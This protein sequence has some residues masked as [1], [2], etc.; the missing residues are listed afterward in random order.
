[1]PESVNAYPTYDGFIFLAI[2]NDVQWQ[3]LTNI[4]KFSA[5]ANDV[6]ISNDGRHLQRDSIHSD[7]A[8]ITLK[9]SM[10]ELTTDFK[11]NKIPF[12]PIEIEAMAVIAD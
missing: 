4:D 6:S 2:G 12:A 3:R 7:I 5:I 9:Y 1:L 11:Q 10:Q 8:K